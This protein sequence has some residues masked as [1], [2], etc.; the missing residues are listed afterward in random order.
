MKEQWKKELEPFAILVAGVNEDL[1][2]RAEEDLRALL[3]ACNQPTITN[4]WYWTY[5]AAKW[6]Q[7]L[8]EEELARRNYAAS[9]EPLHGK[10]AY[11]NSEA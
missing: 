1:E 6:I 9:M 4:C 11:Q 3:D 8:V 5:K 7:P 2:N 10:D